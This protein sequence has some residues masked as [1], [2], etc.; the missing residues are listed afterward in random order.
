M[1]LLFS[2]VLSLSSS[3]RV[4]GFSSAVRFLLPGKIPPF[5]GNPGGSTLWSGVRTRER[6]RSSHMTE[7]VEHL[8]ETAE[9]GTIGFQT[10]VVWNTGSRGWIFTFLILWL[11]M[12]ILF[13]RKLPG[14]GYMS[15]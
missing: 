2:L 14:F 6:C 13:N 11:Q 5:H 10:H 1:F 4:C 7:E 8:P 9:S 12:K 15:L 3:L